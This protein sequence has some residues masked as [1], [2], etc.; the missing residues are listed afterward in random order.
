MSAGGFFR[1]GVSGGERKR[2]SIAVE[3]LQEPSVLLLVRW[4]VQEVGRGREGL[5]RPTDQHAVA[6]TPCSRSTCTLPLLPPAC[7]QDEPTSGLDATTSM[8]LL[9]VL[10]QLAGGG[11]TLCATLHQPSSRLFAQLDK[12]LLLS[13]VRG[14]RWAALW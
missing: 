8:H 13:Q 9:G 7:L 1:K 10:R 6:I 3:L 2:A 4:G 12:L 5:L 14:G 11:R